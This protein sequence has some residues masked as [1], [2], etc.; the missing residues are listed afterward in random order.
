[1][2]VLGLTEELINL[3]KSSTDHPVTVP[4]QVVP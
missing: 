4:V 2:S 1:M 3:E